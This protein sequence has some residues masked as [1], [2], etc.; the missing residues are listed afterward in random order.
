LSVVLLGEK[1]FVFTHGF[2]SNNNLR[3][4]HI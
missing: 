3:L 2:L 4:S 1:K